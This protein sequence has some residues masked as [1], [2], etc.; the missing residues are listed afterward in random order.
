MRWRVTEKARAA[1]FVGEAFDFLTKQFCKPLARKALDISILPLVLARF[2]GLV[3]LLQDT[4]DRQWSR[5][6]EAAEKAA[7]EGIAVKIDTF[8]E[9]GG[10]AQA[11]PFTSAGFTNGS[12]Q[13]VFCVT[14]A[15]QGAVAQR[16]VVDAF[17]EHC[18]VNSVM[19]AKNAARTPLMT[20]MRRRPLEEDAE[21]RGQRA[22][23][24]SRIEV[25]LFA[26]REVEELEERG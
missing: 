7:N 12:P 17:V 26:L 8:S 22:T 5:H 9:S 2:G 25:L 21:R 18:L 11:S 10:A 19:A 15:F 3:K 13:F 4:I 14:N 20:M 1:R 24:V 23:L 16:I 6:R